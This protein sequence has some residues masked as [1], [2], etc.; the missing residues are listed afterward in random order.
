MS[1]GENDYDTSAPVSQE[2][3]AYADEPPTDPYHIEP[4]LLP[5][6]VKVEFRS[7]ATLTAANFRWLRG[8]D[9]RE[10]QMAFYQEVQARAID[11]L[12]DG[13]TLTAPSG[14]PV[15]PPR[16]AAKGAERAYL[17]VMSGFDMA[18]LERHLRG[19]ID[20]LLGDREDAAGE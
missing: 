6:G 17:K 16:Y 19:P 15:L 4:V 3:E 11:L 12:V 1:F 2:H 13:W 7:M 20:T 5:S 10:G 8:A 14:R 18:A 9:D